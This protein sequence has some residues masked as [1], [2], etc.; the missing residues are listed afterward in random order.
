MDPSSKPEGSSAD[1]VPFVPPIAEPEDRGLAVPGWIEEAIELNEIHQLASRS[2]RTIDAYRNQWSRFVR[3]CQDHDLP[4]EAFALPV[5]PDL[6]A[7]YL[8]MWHAEGSMAVST[9]VQALAA[10]RWVHAEAELEAPTSA[11]LEK[12]VGSAPASV[13]S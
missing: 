12:T 13:D 8:S 10:I 4:D 5:T 7:I 1:L 2:P 6:I 3:W 11:R 9:M